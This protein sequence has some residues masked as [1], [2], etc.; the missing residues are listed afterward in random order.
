MGN[1]GRAHE[2]H[3]YRDRSIKV[4]GVER[5]VHVVR[6]VTVAPP[7]MAPPASAPEPAE[8]HSMGSVQSLFECISLLHWACKLLLSSQNISFLEFRSS[9]AY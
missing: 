7:L 9:M 6:A 1:G 4:R 2:K 8:A 3:M 5:G